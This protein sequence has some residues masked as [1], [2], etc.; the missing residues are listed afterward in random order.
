MRARA[1]T[2]GK[3]MARRAACSSCSSHVSTTRT[4]QGSS[5][6]STTRE[7]P[8]QLAAAAAGPRPRALP[9]PHLAALVVV[10]TCQ[11]PALV[12]QLRHVSRT[13]QRRQHGGHVQPARIGQR[14]L[15]RR[16]RLR[17]ERRRHKHCRHGRA[18]R[19]AGDDAGAGGAAEAAGAAAPAKD[20]RCT[21][22]TAR[23]C[24][25]RAL[26]RRPAAADTTHPCRAACRLRRRR[27]GRPFR[28]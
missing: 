1:H 4:L 24:K 20:V 8:V 21:G 27:A 18:R 2:R 11:L 10:V 26:P 5:H 6:V 25:P 9:P 7:A 15:N 14:L 16:V 23:E 12:Q 19:D 28:C 3:H 13:Q 17:D 22:S